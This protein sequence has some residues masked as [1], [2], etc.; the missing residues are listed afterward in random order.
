MKKLLL[1]MIVFSTF[2][3]AR[4]GILLEPYLGMHFNSEVSSNCANDCGFDGVGYGARVAW[5]NLGLM[6]G[7]NYQMSTYDVES[8]SNDGDYS[9]LGV[10]VGYSFPI[11]FRVWYEHILSG[12]L[13]FDGG[14]KWEDHSGSVI[15]LSYTG[16]PLVALNLEIG[17]T[18]FG[19]VNGNSSD[20]D[21]DS[22]FLNISFPFNL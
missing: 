22:Y 20:L 13:D 5:T 9:R 14:T 4:A 7:A 18:S 15:G 16:F 11:M 10:I 2:S 17:S 19:E 21:L 8:S 3:S 1:I 6:I 12:N